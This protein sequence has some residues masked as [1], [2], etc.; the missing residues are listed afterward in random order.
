MNNTSNMKPS[1]VKLSS[2]VFQPVWY[3][4]EPT[5]LR[6]VDDGK[7]TMNRLHNYGI[8]RRLAEGRHQ[9]DL[10]FSK[11]SCSQSLMSS[12]P[13]ELEVGIF[14]VLCRVYILNLL[15]IDGPFTDTIVETAMSKG[16]DAIFS[17]S[18]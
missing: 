14:L 1:L 16:H 8:A 3:S 7:T 2:E 6:E 17:S 11:R 9:P 12:S 4:S 18:L 15:T 10:R 13:D 5:I